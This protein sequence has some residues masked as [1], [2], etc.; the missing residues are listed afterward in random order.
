MIFKYIKRI[1]LARRLGTGL[2]IPCSFFLITNTWAADPI[3]HC[4]RSVSDDAPSIQDKTKTNEA[5]SFDLSESTTIEIMPIDLFQI[6]SGGTVLFGSKPLAACFLDRNN[7]LT[8]QAMSMLDIDPTSLN[9]L[10][11]I[12]SI[13]QSKIYPTR[14]LE[15]MKTCI[16]KHH[17]ALGYLSEVVETDLIGPCF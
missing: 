7:V 9:S 15:Q 10:S 5:L 8:E 14:N 11:M 16:A 2:L 12:D 1:S 17:P 4:S 6:Y 13:V 3:W